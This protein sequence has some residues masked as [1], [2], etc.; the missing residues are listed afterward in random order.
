MQA[1]K[2]RYHTVMI[3]LEGLVPWLEGPDPHIEAQI[4]DLEG[5]TP[6]L[7]RQGPHLD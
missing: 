5:M 3:F 7:K 4:L 2:R 6:C 1:W